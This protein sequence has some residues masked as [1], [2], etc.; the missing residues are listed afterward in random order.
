[1]NVFTII[2]ILAL[3]VGLCVYVGRSIYSIVQ[4]LRQRK[5]DKSNKEV[6][7]IE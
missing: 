5:K 2:F 3:T 6:E 4:T 1:M 7:K